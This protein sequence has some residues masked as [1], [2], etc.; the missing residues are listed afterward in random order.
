MIWKRIWLTSASDRV[1][2]ARVPSRERSGAVPPTS[3]QSGSRGVVPHDAGVAG[4]VKSSHV[5]G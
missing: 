3:A 1:T 5:H 4:R 2:T